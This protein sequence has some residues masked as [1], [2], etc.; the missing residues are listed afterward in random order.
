MELLE[1]EQYEDTLGTVLLEAR[2]GTG[3]TVLIGG[4]AGVGKTALVEHFVAERGRSAR[5]LW[6]A[7]DALLTPRPLGPLHDIIRQAPADLGKLLDSDGDW[8]AVASAILA[9]LAR[10]ASPT[11]VV[12]EDAHWADEATLDLLRFLGRRMAQTRAMLIITYRD[13]ELG[14]QHPLRRVLGDLPARATIRLT[15]PRLSEAAVDRLARQA[16]RPVEGLYAATG[17]NPFFVT[18][19]LAHEAEDLPATVRDAVLGRAARLSPPAR[20]VLDLA[21][22]VPGA[23]EQWL[24]AAVCGPPAHQI[25]EC[26]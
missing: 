25:E 17:G 5:V 8:L 13:D 9:W 4:E 23:I 11:V 7:C 24:V 21:S 15:L 14:P 2:N 16:G 20:R 12:V 26:G 18:E 1:R 10:G 3:R 6:G 19:V 22:I